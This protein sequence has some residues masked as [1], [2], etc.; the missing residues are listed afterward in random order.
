MVRIIFALLSVVLFSFAPSAFKEYDAHV[1]SVY[2][3]DT[4][5]TDIELGFGVKLDDQKIRL[6]G[7]DAPEV[8][9][10]EREEGLVSR[11]ALRELIDGKDV[12]IVDRGK[13]K[14]GRI[15]AEVL[16]DTINVSVWMVQNGYAEYAE[17]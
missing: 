13:G 9:G 12:I 5:T 8:R 10:P 4:I 2:D 11:D 1:E 15:I 14:Y 7:I 3:G 16:L 6:Y 17:Y